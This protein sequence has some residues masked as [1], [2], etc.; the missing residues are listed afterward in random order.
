MAPSDAHLLSA[1]IIDAPIPVVRASGELDLSTV[2][3][4]CHAIHVVAATRARPRLIVDLTGLEFCDST[5]LRGLIGGIKEV[6]VL[7]GKAVVAVHPGGVLDRLLDLSGLREFLRVTDSV[8][9]A[10]HRLG[11]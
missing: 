3:Q 11:G 9:A 1:E 10:Q 8:V 6:D 2:A 5:G 4:L 7:G